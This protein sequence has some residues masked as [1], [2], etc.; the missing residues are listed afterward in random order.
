MKNQ[1]DLVT[2]VTDENGV[3]IEVYAD[4]SNGRVYVGHEKGVYKGTSVDGY[5]AIRHYD[6]DDFEKIKQGG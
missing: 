6:S 3:E 5:G 2:I 4:R 1:L